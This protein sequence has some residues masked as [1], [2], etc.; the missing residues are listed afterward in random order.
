MH[1][2]RLA[3]G[4]HPAG[5]EADEPLDAP[6]RA[7]ARCARSTRSRPRATHVADRRDELVGL[8]VGEPGADLVEQQDHRIGCRARGRVRASC[9]PAGR[10]SRHA[11]W[12]PST[13]PQ[14]SSTSTQRAFAAGAAKAAAGRRSRRR[15]S[16]TPS[17]RRTAAAPGGRGR[18]RAGS[19]G[20]PR[21]GVTSAP[22]NATEP[23]DGRRRAREDVQQRRLAGAV[24]AD[25]ADGIAG[26]DR[27]IDAVEDDQRPEASCGSRRRRGSVSSVRS[28]LCRRV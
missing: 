1:R 5:V 4:D 14:S 24:G 23:S 6:A 18:S 9:G 27:E 12:R 20:S 21:R 10:G 16:R 7:R 15:R 8:G 26:P 3:V 13:S 28:H 25:D 2:L 22:R 11:G 19:A 17:C